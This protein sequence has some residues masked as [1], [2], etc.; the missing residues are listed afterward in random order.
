MFIAAMER[1]HTGTEGKELGI[2]RE[3]QEGQR[4]KAQRED[5][6]Q[7]IGNEED[8]EVVSGLS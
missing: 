2:S 6:V 1:K 3:M 7:W 5:E 4:A 8:W